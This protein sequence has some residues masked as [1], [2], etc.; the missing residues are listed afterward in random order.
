MIIIFTASIYDVPLQVMKV[1][2]IS[3][4]I[5]L[6]S[7]SSHPLTSVASQSNCGMFFFLVCVYVKVI[8]VSTYN[9]NTNDEII[10]F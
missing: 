8:Q 4:D 6:A 7:V 2:Y 1:N 9:L 10:C 3:G 5:K